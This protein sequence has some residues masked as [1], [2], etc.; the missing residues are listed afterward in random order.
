MIC[1]LAPGL[2]YVGKLKGFAWPPDKLGLPLRQY[3]GYFT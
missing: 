2:K 1:L 3:C